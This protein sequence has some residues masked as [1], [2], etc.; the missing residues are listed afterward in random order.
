VPASQKLQS[1][2]TGIFEKYQGNPEAS[3]PSF[4]VYSAKSGSNYLLGANPDSSFL[5]ASVTKLFTAV[6]VLRLHDQGILSINDSLDKYLTDSELKDLLKSNGADVAGEL[7]LVQLLANRSGLANYYRLKSLNAR[8]DIA[9]V[10]EADP[11]WDFQEVLA[12]TKTLSPETKK[13]SRRASYSFTNFQILSEVIERAT[14]KQL[15]E[16]FENEVYSPAGLKESKLLTKKNIDDF[17]SA[18]PILFGKQKYLG[19][20]RM[21]SLRGEGALVS[22]SADLVSFLTQLN[23]G[24]L[25]SGQWVERMRKPSSPMFPFIRYGL[26]LMKVQIP[27]PLIGTMRTPELYGHLGATG[28]FAFWEKRTDSYVAGTVNQLGNRTLGSKMFFEIV[29]KIMKRL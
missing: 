11:G 20:S 26:G 17:Y 15:Q 9:R 4:N 6:V 7:T 22:T 24:K 21:A 28:S 1:E 19:S 5:A 10:S 29:A 12:L 3:Q 2:L 18:S 23:Q 8:S 25:I 16:V 14:G 27:G 13:V